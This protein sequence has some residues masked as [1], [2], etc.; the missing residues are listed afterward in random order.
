VN[1][2]QQGL[3]AAIKASEGMWVEFG[4]VEERYATGGARQKDDFDALV[5]ARRHRSLGPA[6]NTSSWILSNKTLVS[7]HRRGLVLREMRQATGSWSEWHPTEISWWT[8]APRPGFAQ[9]EWN[10]RL[11]WADSGL[12]FSYVPGWQ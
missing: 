2:R 3:L 8:I 5:F 9:P 12:D 7:L 10:S 6:K 1:N 11:S 4:V